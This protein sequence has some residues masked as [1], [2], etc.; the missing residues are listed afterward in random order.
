MVKVVGFPLQSWTR[1]GPAGTW[2]LFS[3]VLDPEMNFADED[4]KEKRREGGGGFIYTHPDPS[5]RP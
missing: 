1:K 5:T 2:P 3:A 4:E